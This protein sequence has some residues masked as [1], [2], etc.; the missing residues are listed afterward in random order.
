[1]A[2]AFG[3]RRFVSSTALLTVGVA[4]VLASLATSRA[5]RLAVT[6]LVAAAVWWNVAVMVQFGAGWMD[7]Q[8]L[9]P[10]AIAYNTFV[11]VPRAVPELV[12][13]YFVDRSSFYQSR[14]A[15]GTR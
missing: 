10:A 6:L 12:W 8:R 3:Q 13:R 2:G 11:V 7:R 14:R 9:E 4:A 5:R 15:P 1:V